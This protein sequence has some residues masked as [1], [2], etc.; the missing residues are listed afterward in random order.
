ML[1]L[2]KVPEKTKYAS[3]ECLQYIEP[4]FYKPEPMINPWLPPS[5]EEK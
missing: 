3:E 2:Q 4:E 1:T 5:Q